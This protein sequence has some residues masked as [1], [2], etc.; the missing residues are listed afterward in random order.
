MEESPRLSRN[1]FIKFILANQLNIFLSIISSNCNITSTGNEVDRSS[2]SEF[3]HQYLISLE[4]E[5]V[6]CSVIVKFSERSSGFGYDLRTDISLS[7]EWVTYWSDH[8]ISLYLM[9][10]DRRGTRTSL[11][12]SPLL[13]SLA[14]FQLRDIRKNLAKDTSTN[15]PSYRA[16]PSTRPS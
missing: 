12:I 15:I 7:C 14:N 4:R 10:L 6:P 16:F 2:N 11:T 13:V 9:K 1:L 3:Y 8:H 5:D